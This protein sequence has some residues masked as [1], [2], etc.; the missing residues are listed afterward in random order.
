MTSSTEEPQTA[1]HTIEEALDALSALGI[2][3]VVTMQYEDDRWDARC[4][5]K[6]IDGE[7]LPPDSHA[8]WVDQDH[9]VGFYGIGPT[10]LAAHLGLLEAVTAA[11]GGSDV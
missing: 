1:A 5:R 11:A 4:H 8:W 2:N 7:I 3:R 10:P 9:Y 6:I